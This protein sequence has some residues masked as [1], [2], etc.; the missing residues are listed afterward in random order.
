M[1]SPGR[2][3]NDLRFAC[4]YSA[5]YRAV[6]GYSRRRSTN[7]ADADEVVSETFTTAWRRLDSVPPG[8][9]TL[10]WLYG[11]ARR[12]L[13]NQRRGNG[14]RTDL[15]ARLE[16]QVPAVR[17]A[18]DDGLAATKTHEVVLMA[19]A[20]LKPDDQEILRLVVWEALSHRQVAQVLGCADSSVAVRLHRA[21]TRLTKQLLKRGVSTGHQVS[22]MAAG[23]KPGRE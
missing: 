6:L 10:P 15:A 5:H 14:R 22:R 20:Q 12:A 18:I 13:A 8:A 7:T 2:S 11:V 4:I 9:E 17:G 19:L 21:R 1:A 16:R 23:R 3:G